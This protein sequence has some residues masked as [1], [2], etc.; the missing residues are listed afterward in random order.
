MLSPTNGQI[1]LNILDLARRTRVDS[2]SVAALSPEG[3]RISA[4]T[5]APPRAT[6]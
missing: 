5:V 3:F 2:V 4:I 1:L 6:R